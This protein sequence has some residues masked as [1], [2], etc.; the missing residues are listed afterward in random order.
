[1]FYLSVFLPLVSFFT[2]MILNK[3]IPDLKI[4]GLISLLM[5]I[6]SLIS[7][8][9]FFYIYHYGSDSSVTLGTWL[10]SGSFYIDWSLNYNSL[11]VLM[12]L[13]VNLVSTVVHIYSI[14]YM[15]NDPKKIIFLGY[16][17]LFTFFML[18]LVTSSNLIQLFLGWEG[19]G[20]TSY[21]LIGF[22]NKKESANKAA[23]KAFIINR[24]GD[25]GFLL[26]IFSIFI[27]FGTVNFNEIFILVDTQESTYFNFLGVNFH[28]LTL[29]SILLFI[30]SM[31]KSAQFGLHTW[32]PD[33][34]EG[35]TPVSAL[36]H[37]AT[38]VTAGVF[39]LVLMSPILEQSDFAQKLVMVVGAF[40]S[41]FAA[42]VAITQNDIKKIIAYSTC[43]QLGYMFVAIGA[44]AYGLAMFHLVTHAF[45]KA[46]LFLG[47][48]SV[49]HAMSDEQNIKKMGGLYNKIPITYLLMIIGTL[50]LVGFPFFS[51]YYSKDLIL[52]V[53]Y[54]DD[55]T[56]KNYVY[57]VQVFVVFLTSFYSFRLIIYVFHG[58]NNS[59]EKVFAHIHESP[60]IMLYP[61]LFLA[62]FSIFS[63]LFFHDYFFG[64][65]SFQFWQGTIFNIYN[66][67]IS[68]MVQSLPLYIKKL[69]FLMIILGFFTSLL[70][71]FYSQ[72]TNI[73]L[74][75]HL[76]YLYI[77]CREK[78]FIDELYEK[79]I[80][81]P[82]RYIGIGFWN[83]IDK[84]LI[85]NIGPNGISRIIK[86]LGVYVSQLQT[87]YLYH[88][89]LT[90]IIGLTIFISIY[91]YT[92]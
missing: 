83:S 39:L 21:L 67:E 25:F 30:G 64:L 50:S 82:T 72:K 71:C 46:L 23:L 84:E 33:A 56:I 3:R 74:K 20:L 76:S 78:W 66:A 57:F 41:L 34:M 68:S 6:C 36:I 55:F 15:E 86:R 58:Q 9:L 70:L 32:L 90:V 89:A 47:A 73:F 51:A 81:K 87:G 88:Y 12:V 85:D 24:V 65:E 49:I 13:V 48:G 80:V 4:E 16:L 26:G 29:I 8:Y 62:F 7:L 28:A 59:D 42:T 38:M 79:L 61:L 31:G 69:P 92:L 75:K 19:V 43:S 63:G 17:G 52:E 53:L 14:G 27:V 10:T 18:M 35:P 40:T 54:L 5:I 2:C 60:N 1:M 45:F 37:A 22:W 77:F 91:F 44:S 11:S